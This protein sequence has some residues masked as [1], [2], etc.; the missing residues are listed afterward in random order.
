MIYI[1]LLPVRAAQK[2]EKLVEQII[3]FALATSLVIA[4]CIGV[5]GVLLTKIMAEKNEISVKEQRIASL[6][7]KIQ[8]VKN[9]EKLQ[10]ELRVKLDILDKLKA[11][12]SG[13]TRLLDALASAIPDN[14]WLESYKEA[15]GKISLSGL[16]MSEEI[17]AVFMQNLEASDYFK[18]VELQVTDQTLRSK[19]KLTKFAINCVAEAPA[20]A[21]VKK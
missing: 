4:G 20:A 6:Q 3:I 1:N 17:V 11:G 19:I 12:R 14:L 16:A 18:S 8:E 21:N 10:N 15:G 9:F 7:K 13:P 5:Y 2:K